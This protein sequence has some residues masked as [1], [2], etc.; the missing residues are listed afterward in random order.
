[1]QKGANKSPFATDPTI[2]ELVGSFDED[3][4][5]AR[6]SYDFTFDPYFARDHPEIIEDA[7]SNTG[8]PSFSSWCVGVGLAMNGSVA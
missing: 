5:A 1:M 8:H 7:P 6:P 3:R 4:A 2:V